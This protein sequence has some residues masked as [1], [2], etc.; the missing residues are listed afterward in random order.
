MNIYTACTV[1]TPF[2][3]LV[4]LSTAERPALI[5]SSGAVDIV[6]KAG[7]TTKAPKLQEY[8]MANTY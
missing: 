2:L 3:K 5:T 4:M 7:S 1:K 8:L 6:V